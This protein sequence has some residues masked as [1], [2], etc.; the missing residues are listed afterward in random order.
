MERRLDLV[1]V[2]YRGLIGKWQFGSTVH[3]DKSS[4]DDDNDD[5]VQAECGQPY[6]VVL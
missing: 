5:A 3:A 6:L 4:S 2:A 1:Q